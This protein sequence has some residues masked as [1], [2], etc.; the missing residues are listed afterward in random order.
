VLAHLVTPTF[1]P[2]KDLI[3]IDLA[4]LE[5]EAAA[6]VTVIVASW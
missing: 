1:W 3:D 4:P 6:L 5:A 2:A